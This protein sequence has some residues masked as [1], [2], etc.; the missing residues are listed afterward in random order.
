MIFGLCIRQLSHSRLYVSQMDRK[1]NINGDIISQ[2]V[3]FFFFFF[4]FRTNE[5]NWYGQERSMRGRHGSEP[6]LLNVPIF[7]RAVKL[8][9]LGGWQAWT[10]TERYNMHTSSNVLRKGRCWIGKPLFHN[11]S[12]VNSIIFCLHQ[13]QS[14]KATFIFPLI[15]VQFY[16]Q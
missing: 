3:F 5:S 10:H 7:M 4:L 13:P 12:F 1:S 2:E 15:A 8:S 9:V 14:V 11:C 6:S 16:G